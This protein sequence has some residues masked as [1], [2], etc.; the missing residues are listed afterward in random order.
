MTLTTIHKMCNNV[1][2]SFLLYRI[3]NTVHK[4]FVQTQIYG[5]YH[6]VQKVQAFISKQ[7]DNLYL[8]HNT[9]SS[10]IHNSTM[11]STCLP[12]P[13]VRVSC[14]LNTLSMV[15]VPTHQPDTTTFLYFCHYIMSINL[16]CF[17]SISLENKLIGMPASHILK[18]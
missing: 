2:W 1:D 5:K 15:S 11:I 6:S 10:V 14:L 9:N 18:K 17:T 4:V 12:A 3:S 16:Y 7:K 8:Q 13:H